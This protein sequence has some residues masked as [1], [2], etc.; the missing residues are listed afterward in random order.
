MIKLSELK[1][2]EVLLVNNELVLTK[3]EFLEDFP[4]QED[5]EGCEIFTTI[6]Y[7]AY[8]NAR[9]I[10]DKAIEDE[11]C[12]KMYDEWIDKIHNDITED[13]VKEFQNILDRILL[14]NVKQNISYQTD[15]EVDIDI[16]EEEKKNED[17]TNK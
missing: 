5:R 6:K 2:D 16:A 1:D 3:K 14:R 9:D 8:L 7:H 12:D 4:T 10:L 11:A 15:Q 17:N 13:D